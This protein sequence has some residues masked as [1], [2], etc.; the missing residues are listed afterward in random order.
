M[1]LLDNKV[2]IITGAGSGLGRA[3]ALLLAK[4][5]AGV[6]VNDFN[7]E[8]AAKVVHEIEV[9]GGRAVAAVADVSSMAGGESILVTAL[10][11]F[12]RVDILI[13]NAGILRDK[14]LANLSEEMWDAVV[15]VHLKGT[16]CVTQ[17][18][19]RWMKDN[20]AGGV[21][22]NTSSSSGLAGN[23][24]QTNYGAAKA[25]IWGFSNSLALEGKKYGIR[26]WTLVPAAVTPLTANVLPSELS[27]SWSPERVAPVILYMVSSL[28][29]DKTNRTIFASG[30]KIMELKM[31]SGP[32]LS[33]PGGLTA[34]DIAASDKDLF[35]DDKGLDFNP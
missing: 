20:K 34:R 26:V 23:V 15:N 1:G 32:V 18:V 22:V 35:L 28:S 11:A 5:G 17:P 6:V 7:A 13:N 30:T 19:F 14:G 25:G 31:V 33:N 29:G 9:N 10:E 24:G 3:Y 4:E 27:Q 21:I 16:F 8:N 2:A 12:G